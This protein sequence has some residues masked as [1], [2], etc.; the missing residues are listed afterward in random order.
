MKNKIILAALMLSSSCAFADSGYVGVSAGSVTQD[1]SAQGETLSKTS[2]GAKLYGGYRIS[3]ALGV[4]AAY[5][6]FG[7]ASTTAEGLTV[8]SKPKSYY[9]A[10]TGTM[11]VSPVF[12]VSAKL[13]VARTDTTLFVAI[14][15]ERAAGKDTGTSA[16]FGVGAQYKF[17]ET[18]SLVAEYEN[19][20]KVAKDEQSSL[21]LKVSMF[22]VGVRVSF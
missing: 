4:E 5:V 22:S 7:E 2:T 9:A 19:Y 3:P 1:L 16:M 21:N 11:A 10:V 12:S 6:H 8:G 18:V 17:S 15:G 13:G 20:G 14:D